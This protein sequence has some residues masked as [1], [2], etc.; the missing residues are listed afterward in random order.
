MV[1]VQRTSLGVVVECEGDCSCLHAV[2]QR[3]LVNGGITGA[4]H[5]CVWD[6]GDVC[7]GEWMGGQRHWRACQCMCGNGGTLRGG[8]EAGVCVM[9]VVCGKVG[10]FLSH[11]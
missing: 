6:T 8:Q 1:W 3:M 2:L 11:P 4:E 9:D 7:V 10:G 5:W